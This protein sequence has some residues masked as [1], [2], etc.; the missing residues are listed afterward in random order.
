MGTDLL[1]LK[2]EMTSTSPNRLD[3]LPSLLRGMYDSAKPD[4][5]EIL[6]KP[7]YVS[8]PKDTYSFLHKGGSPLTIEQILPTDETLFI[9]CGGR[10]N[11]KIRSKWTI[12]IAQ[13]LGIDPRYISLIQGTAIDLEWFGEEG[14]CGD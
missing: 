14:Y 11:D 9:C 7:I 8:N 1:T 4:H 10:L 5:P 6:G 12:I 2:R 13:R 3:S